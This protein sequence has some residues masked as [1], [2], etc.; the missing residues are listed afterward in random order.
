[1]SQQH[2]SRAPVTPAAF[3]LRAGSR[4]LS[5]LT[6]PEPLFYQLFYET[7]TIAATSMQIRPLSKIEQL[8]EPRIILEEKGD[9]VT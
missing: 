9:H 5:R 3:R 4:Q 6:E 1:M 2:K 8:A 7:S